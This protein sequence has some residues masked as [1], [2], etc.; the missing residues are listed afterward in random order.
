[1]KKPKILVEICANSYQSAINAEL[2][3]AHRLEL[4]SNLSVG[5]TTPSPA[6]IELT[7]KNVSLELFVL[8]RPRGGDFFYSDHEF[9]LMK[10]NIRF[11]K[12]AGVA[13]I[14]SGVL[15][16]DGAIDQKRTETLIAL[17]RPM[18]FTFHRAFDRLKNPISALEQL[19]EM[20]VDRVLTS[21]QQQRAIEGIGLL[22]QL[23]KTA[24]DRIHILAGSG[25]NVDNAME[26]IKKTGVQEIHFSAKKI[27][28]SKINQSESTVRF[29]ADGDAELNY[30]ETNV[31]TVKQVMELMEESFEG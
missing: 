30:F 31:A 19:I 2:G 9:E 26:I 15:D 6:T 8:I 17:A 13:G 16:S 5:G 25:I 7:S 18:T 22:E 11:C 23:V 14:V 4:C 12:S 3:G 24:A 1:M 28:K 29:S 21:G 20:G 10:E 27:V